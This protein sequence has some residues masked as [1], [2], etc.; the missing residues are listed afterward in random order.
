MILQSLQCT[1]CA[2]SAGCSVPAVLAVP[3]TLSS[4]VDAVVMQW[5]QY[6]TRWMQYVVMEDAGPMKVDAVNLQWLQCP[7]QFP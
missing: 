1:G 5:M 6:P 3:P 4:N 2:T 7:L